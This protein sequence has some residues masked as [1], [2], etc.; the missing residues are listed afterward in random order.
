MSITQFAIEKNR[1]TITALI[2]IILGGISAYFNMPQDEDPGFTIRTAVV[3]TYFPGAS[4]ERVENLVTDKLEKVIQQIPEL[5]YISSESR[6]GMSI[7]YVNIKERYKK[8]R[9]IWD[10]LRRK[11]ESA[12][13]ELPTGIIGPFINDDFGDVFGIV[14]SI[15]GEGFSEAEMK[16]IAEDIRDELLHLDEV[17]KVD[18]YGAQEERIFVE[19][20]NAQLAELGLSPMHLQAFLEGQ[21][22]IIP[23]G[24][25]EV[26]H[27][28]IVLEPSGN[29]ENLE[30]IKHT[31]IRLPRNIDMASLRELVSGYIDL[32]RGNDVVYLGDLATVK[33]GY[34]DPP[35]TKMRF[36]GIPALSLAVS[37]RE[38]GNII[39]LGEEV[40]ALVE[41]LQNQLFIGIDLHI[42]YFQP[43]E[44]SKIIDDFIGNL[45][46]A[47]LLVI[48]VLLVSLGW[49]TGLLVSI[50]IP[51]TIVMAF[52]I[53]PFFDIGVNQMSLAALLIAL[54]MLV[55]SSI[56][57]SESIM[58]QMQNGKKSL[59]AAIDSA[60]E[61][62][63]PLLI[64]ALTTSAAFLPI[65]LAKSAV[66]EYLG[67]IALMLAITL[68]S[69]WMLAL[70]LIPLLCVTFMKVKSTRKEEQ[71][72]SKFYAW[73][74]TLLLTVLRHPGRTV[75]GVILVF[76]LAIFALQ[77][78]PQKFFP[79]SD[80]TV[81]SLELELPPGSAIE[82]TEE[83]IEEVENYIQNTLMVDSARSEGVVHFGS[84]IGQGAPRYILPYSPE[85]VRPEYAYMLIYTS[86]YA[87][88]QDVISAL[89]IYCRSQ[90]PDLEAIAKVL[91]MGIPADP[92][93]VRIS[94]KDPDKLY[95]IVDQVKEK[96]RNTPGTKHI[97]DDWGAKIK[98]IQ[99][100]ISETRARR[101]G[102]SNQDVAVSLQTMLSGFETT[103]Y[104]EDDK[105]IPIT[106]RSVAADRQDIGKLESLNIYSQLT[107]ASVP[108]KQVADIEL[109]WQPSKIL[110][111]NRYK[112]I[113]VSSELEEGYTA[114]EINRHLI[115]WL[116]TQQQQW[117]L[118]YRYEIGGEQEES[119]KANNSIFEQLP[120]AGLVILL[121]LMLQFNSFRK[122]TLL[123]LTIPLGFI[124]VT[125]GLLVTSSYFGFMTL[126]GLV[127]L[128]GIV[129]Q[130]GNVLLE[131][132]K[133]EME[134]N[135]HS[136]VQAIVEATQRR[137]RPILLTATTTIGGLLPLWLGGGPLWEPMAIAII[138]GLLV[139]T[140]TTLL[141][142][143]AG[144]SL[145]YRIRFKEFSYSKNGQTKIEESALITNSNFK[146]QMK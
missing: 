31:V 89:E 53:M 37:L 15:T 54:G 111:R 12:T 116:E 88:N 63:R 118:G 130:N 132:I 16:D 84:F 17:A 107:G 113:S 33:R 48:F 140:L 67:S 81:V 28:R 110:R 117:G 49:R 68:L 95:A 79:D 142:F 50:L 100:N 39:T 120:I 134:K 2:V 34:V 126:L 97:G 74:R 55:D 133:I 64:S 35:Q 61:L 145:F 25:I 8:M 141:V 58:V 98:K 66:G 60:K 94:G 108:L 57:M 139:A 44:V 101:A 85:Q 109:E 82:Y 119:G 121:L 7:V 4:P 18:I 131:R 80:R 83:V 70:T 93:E 102:L 46:Q 104:R 59:R 47:V 90:F 77:W 51:A 99:V 96:L 9:P 21:N 135:G 112:T 75:S 20:N 137:L 127:S 45:I 3:I 71:Y 65:S 5:D 76:A 11:V 10:D 124:G 36:N 56:V 24:D 43:W 27:E 62:R 86:S 26:G 29:F 19:F 42:L 73:F 114:F 41:R 146:E 115:P 23:G 138:F 52:L 128:S 1:V 103:Q 40:K 144:Y 123:L 69:A 92:V 78:I 143:P 72:G 106:L 87:T 105:V 91:P 38:G 22:I 122:T 30:D 136:P 13:N 125:I 6:T 32:P 14:L 129:L